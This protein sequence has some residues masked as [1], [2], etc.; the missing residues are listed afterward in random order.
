MIVFHA[1]NNK[2]EEFQIKNVPVTK[3]GVGWTFS[4]DK[5]AISR[6]GKFIYKLSI[7][8]SGMLKTDVNGWI[9]EY[10]EKV[11]D[12]IRGGQTD[13]L[14]KFGKLAINATEGY[15]NELQKLP[16]YRALQEIRA[17]LYSGDEQQWAIRTSE[18]VGISSIAVG[19]TQSMV[20]CWD[21]SKIESYRL[22][23]ISQ[24]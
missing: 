3:Y 17:N 6:Y 24:R 21:P 12:L 23:E 16:L 18:I 13:R 11:T 7:D 5:A 4:T 10:K 8:P 9:D 22:V 2:T 15:I 20:L 19:N 1:S 14:F